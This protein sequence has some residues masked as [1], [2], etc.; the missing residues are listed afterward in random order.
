MEQTRNL[1]HEIEPTIYTQRQAIGRIEAVVTGVN[2]GPERAPK[3]GWKPFEVNQRWGGFDQT[4]WFRMTLTIPESMKGQRVV[5]FVRPGGEALTYVNGK[6]M[7]GLDYNRD[8]IYLTNSA[9][10]GE[11]F[12][13]V[14]E[15]VPSVRFDEYHH[16]QYADFGVMRPQV[17]DF[18]WDCKVVY[19]ICKELDANF[20][21]RRQM[22]NLLDVC[23]KSIDLQHVNEPAYFDSIAQAGKRLRAGMKDF[24]A[25]FGMGK[26][27]IMGQSH[28]DTAWLWPLRETRRKCGRTFS[29]VLAMLD[30]YP[31]FIFMA[32]QAVQYE[33]MKE[34]YPE[35][36]A[37]IK[38]YVKQ[39]RWEVCGAMWVES[40]CNVPSGEA[41]IRQFLYGNRFFR[42]EFGVHSRT[43]WLPDAFGYTWAMP[44][45]IR[46]CQIDTF[47]TTKIDWSR[48]TK[49]PHSVFQWEGIDGT[50]V[51]GMMPPLN[52]NGNIVPKDCL[53]QWNLFRQKDVID[54]VPFAFGF[55]DGGG[56]PT[57]AMIEFGKRMKNIAGMPK[58]EF[59][60]MQDSIDRMRAQYPQDKLPVYNNELYLEYHRGCQTSQARTKRNNRKSEF[61]MRQTEFVSSLDHINGGKYDQANIYDAWKTVLTNQ[62]HDIVPGSS[63]NEVYAQADIDYAAAQKLARGV[64]DTALKHL[65]GVIDTSGDG[66]AVVVFNTLSWKRTDLVEIKVKLPKGAFRIVDADSNPA[67][68][69]KLANGN[70]L[71]KAVDVPAMGY[72]VYNLTQGECTACPLPLSASTSV[73]ENAYLRAKFDKKGNLVSVFDKV[74]R[75]EVGQKGKVLNDL[76]LFDDRD[77]AW[78]VNHNFEEKMWAPKPVE[79]IEVIEVGPLRAVVRFVRRTEKSEIVQD[80]TLY[81][82]TNRLDFVTHVNWQEKHVLL[83]A[84]FPVDVRSSMATYETQFGAIQRATHHNTE[85][86]AGRFEVPAHKWADLSEGGDYGVSL[87]NDCKYGYDV[88]DNVLRISLLRAPTDPDPHADEGEHD[89]T[90]SLYPHEGE[91]RGGTVQEGFALNET[92]LAVVSEPAAGKLPKMQGFASVD[93]ENVLIDHVKRAEDSSAL[94]VRVY[95]A[96]GRRGAVNLALGRVPKSV[97]ECDMMEEND[98]PVK[99]KGSTVSFVVTPFEIRTFKVQY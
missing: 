2:K 85:F 79:S 5:A 58:L 62:F 45:I 37:R 98:V 40:D 93:V 73:M 14:L 86:D 43:V 81:E 22:M 38:K 30:R 26:L 9:K 27:A 88:H 15:A 63:I 21:P 35:N 77:N 52:Y 31:E 66:P 84:S 92:L 97:T 57:M 95:E 59:S 76:Q 60:R 65:V 16:F 39:G 10:P 29:T 71:I 32:S 70:L 50:K 61:L 82:H 94:I 83:K 8:E 18:Y 44:Q 72:K 75:R 36:Y 25:S 19:E 48:Y 90:Y 4:T 96:Y 67:P 69:Q 42:K 49:F 7:Q 55:G 89:F 68:Y 78:D 1:L 3:T 91:W 13:L 12:E 99:M 41:L 34:Q 74:N 11:K 87:L 17:W 20:A 80:V 56:G 53:D 33:W 64:R 47:V 23:M 6:P 54:E 28:I 46:K 51:T 24:E